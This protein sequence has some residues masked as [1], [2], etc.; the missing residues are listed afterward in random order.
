MR[1]GGFEVGA[2]RR[3]FGGLGATETG[4]RSWSGRMGS[5]VEAPTLPSPELI[6]VLAFQ[7]CPGKPTTG[8]R[9]APL[10]VA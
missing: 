8:C 1:G 3:I 2:A 7:T 9:A 6:R 4:R 5:E 10:T